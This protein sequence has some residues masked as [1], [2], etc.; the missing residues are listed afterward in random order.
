MKKLSLLFFPVL[1]ALV[2]IVSPSTGIGQ[3]VD[4]DLQNALDQVKQLRQEFKNAK[5]QEANET[6]KANKAKGQAQRETA[7]QKREEARQRMEKK[8]KEV[9]L[10]LV[11]VQIK[12]MTRTENRVQKM[13][14]ITDGLKNQL[15]AQVDINIQNLNDEKSKIKS[16]EGKDTIK[17]LAKEA[18]DFFKSKY[19]AVKDIVN[20]VFTSRANDAVVKGGK[21]ATA[22]K[23]KIQEMKNKGKDTTEI[24]TDLNNAENDLNGAQEAIERKAFREVNEDLKGAYQK[25]REIAQKAKGL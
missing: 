3:T 7:R 15:I 8:R 4:N 1:V 14:N 12:W 17:T 9:L 2:F 25:F 16:A 5:T 13:P 6:V 24:E 21:R 22:I 20:A 18:R 10:K 11:D 23:T 19:K